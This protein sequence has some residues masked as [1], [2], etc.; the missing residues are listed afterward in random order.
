MVL[1][2]II[3]FVLFFAILRKR[4]TPTGIALGSVGFGV[5][6]VFYFG[7]L[8]TQIQN[9]F[10]VPVWKSGFSSMGG[11]IGAMTAALSM[12]LIFKHKYKILDSQV[13]VL[14]LIYSIAKIGCFCVGCC[15]GISYNGHFC[16]SYPDSLGEKYFPVQ[17]TETIV[18][19]IIFILGVTLLRNKH[20][21]LIVIL[22]MAAKVSLDFLRLSNKGSF[23]FTQWVCVIFLIGMLVYWFLQERKTKS[24]T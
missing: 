6:M 18:F 14:P 17:L 19:M 16:V 20:F 7:L 5:L 24:K 22:S 23:G 8:L 13:R 21:I 3:G 4:Q 12:E 11:A 1:S 2:I 10:A 15:R 9:G